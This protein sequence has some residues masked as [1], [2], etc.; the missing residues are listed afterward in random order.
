MSHANRITLLC[1]GNCGAWYRAARPGKPTAP[2][3]T[4]ERARI[5]A[6][7]EG[8][9]KCTAFGDFCPD[10]DPA[11]PWEPAAVLV[12]LRERRK[13]L[14]LTQAEVARL[15]GTSQSSISEL[16]VGATSPTLNLLSRYA[17]ALGKRLA[18][19]DLFEEGS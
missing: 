16:E 18:L 9:W 4:P 11:L 2:L 5:S 1:D 14:G 19:V 3:E 12:P 7:R 17:A 15:T 8:K 13:E 10:C 6:A